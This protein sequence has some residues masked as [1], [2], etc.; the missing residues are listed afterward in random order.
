MYCDCWYI[1]IYSYCISNSVLSLGFSFSLFY[2]LQ[3]KI[4]VLF[5]IYFIFSCFLPYSKMKILTTFFLFYT[6]ESYTYLSLFIILFISL[7][8]R[9]REWIFDL[10]KFKFIQFGELANNMR[11]LKIWI[12]IFLFL[13]YI[14]FLFKLLL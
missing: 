11:N 6:S 13:S 5:Y 2:I 9:V 10:T 1:W 8:S 7:I 14:L 3:Y 4:H 12:S